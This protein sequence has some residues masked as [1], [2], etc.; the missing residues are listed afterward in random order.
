MFKKGES[1]NVNGR[2]QGATDKAQ[3]DIKQA[4]QSLVEGNLSN[5]ENWLNDVAAKDPAKALDFMLR[6]S[7]YI[8]PKMKATELT[9]ADGKDLIT[10]MT[11]E[12]I[13]RS[14]QILK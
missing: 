4:Y 13:D 2:P 3:K 9:G 8:L 1:G 5:I 7:E 14:D 10:S 6:L 11:I 12:I